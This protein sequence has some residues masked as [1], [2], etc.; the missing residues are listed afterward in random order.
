[1]TYKEKALKLLE[2]SG[3]C[4]VEI[5]KNL[6]ELNNIFQSFDFRNDVSDAFLEKIRPLLTYDVLKHIYDECEFYNTLQDP[7]DV[8][9]CVKTFIERGE[10]SENQKNFLKYYIRTGIRKYV[11]EFKTNLVEFTNKCKEA[12]YI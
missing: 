3:K 10:L 5:G 1:M 7:D 4:T 6:L 9:D 2:E 11:K 8:I 12:G